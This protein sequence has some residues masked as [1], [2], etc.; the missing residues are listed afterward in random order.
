M[1]SG[2]GVDNGTILDSDKSTAEKLV[3]SVDFHHMEGN[4]FYCGWTAHDVVVTPSLA[5]GFHLR[6]T[7]RNTNDIKEYLYDVYYAAL[8]EEVG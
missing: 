8:G 2:S 6:I 5:H 7:G 3:F 4:G 1:P